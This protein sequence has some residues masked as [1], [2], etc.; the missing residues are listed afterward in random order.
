MAVVFKANGTSERISLARGEDTAGKSTV[1]RWFKNFD[2]CEESFVQWSTG[3]GTKNHHRL[4]S[5][6]WIS[7]T[8][9]RPGFQLVE[10][11]MV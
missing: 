11:E 3:C 1:Y 7:T 2:E 10:S 8:D 4:V 5:K 6:E 9:P